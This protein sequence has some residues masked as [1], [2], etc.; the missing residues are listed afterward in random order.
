[1]N[2]VSSEPSTQG[3]LGFLAWNLGFGLESRINS[4]VGASI[5][6]ACATTFCF[7]SVADLHAD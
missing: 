2:P 7:S 4:C 5:L 3:F 6:Y 1:M